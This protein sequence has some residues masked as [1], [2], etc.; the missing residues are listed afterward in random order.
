MSQENVD[1]VMRAMTAAFKR[2]KPGAPA[3][4]RLWTVLTV[5][6]GRITRSEAFL[7]WTEALEA[8]RSRET[9]S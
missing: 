7:D 1:L 9:D 3:N 5:E 4:Q 8:V 6:H 2:P